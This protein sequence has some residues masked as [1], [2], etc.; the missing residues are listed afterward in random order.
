[1]RNYTRLSEGL[2][3]YR[4]VMRSFI[5]TAI[6]KQFP[7]GDWFADRVLP[8]VTPQ[9]MDNLQRDLLR[10]REEGRVGRGKGGPEQVLDITHF[11]RVISANWH[12][13]FSKFLKDR[14]LLTY[15]REVGDARNEWAHP[16]EG[17]SD[18]EDVSRILDSCARVVDV[19]DR[20]TAA[21][22]RE[23]RD[24]KVEVTPQAAPEPEAPA[25]PEAKPSVTGLTPWREVV[26]PHPDV[27][28]GRYQKAEFAADLQEVV[29]GRA[30]A[31]YGDPQEF[32]RRTFVTPDMRRLLVGVAQR[33]RGDG[34]D[35]VI[36]LK[37]AFGGG[38]THTLLAVFHMVNSADKIAQDPDVSGILRDAG[39][40]L[41]A[42][43]STAV[44]VGTY[45][46]PVTPIRL[47][48]ETGGVE[49]HTLWGDMAYQLAGIPGYKLVANH[50]SKGVAPGA[51]VMGRLFELA[52]PSVILIDEL[53]AY[54][55]SVPSRRQS[56]DI[57][58]SYN[59]HITFCQALTEAAKNAE[60]V[61]VLVSVPESNIEYG[62]AHGARIATQI[63]NIFQR[64]GSPWQPVGGHEAFEVVRRRLFGEIKDAVARDKTVDAFYQQYRHGDGEFPPECREPAY[65]ERMRASYP[66]HPEVF[67]RLYVDWAGSIDRFQRTR[68]VLRLM[69][70]AIHRLWVQND[71]EPMIMPGS[72]P[73]YDSNVRQQLVGYL[74]DNW[75]Q[76]MDIDIDG[77]SC[78]ASNIERQN[79]RYGQVQACRRLTRT[80]F[81]GSVPGKAHAGLDV[82]RIFLGTTQPKEGAAVYGDALRTLGGRLS[83]LYGSDNAYWFE[84]RPNLNRM[85]GDRIGRIGDQEALDEIRSRLR[86]PR[87]FQDSG[88]FVTVHSAPES[89]SDVED[90]AR[91]RLVVLGPESPHRNDLDESAAVKQAAAILESRGTTPRTHRNMLVFVAADEETLASVY[92]DTKRYRGWKSI[93]DDAEKGVIS[94]DRGQQRQANESRD[95]AGSTVDARLVEAYRWLIVPEQEGTDPIKYSAMSLSGGGLAST[96][97]LGVRASTRLA[98]DGLLIRTWAPIHLKRELDQWIWKDGQTHVTLKQV[99]AY[100]ATY[101]YFSRLRDEEVFKEVVRNG[102]RTKDYFG[103]A[104]GLDGSRYLGLVFGEPPRNIVIDDSSLL[105]RPEISD[106]QIAE[107]T[108]IASKPGDG[109]VP[110]KPGTDPIGPPPET[111]TATPRRFYG[112]IKLNPARLSSSA[113][114]IGDEI[115]QH[116]KALVGSDVEVTLEI[117]AEIPE[118]IP[119]SVVR[120]ISENAA[121]LKFEQFGF[122]AE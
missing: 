65:A 67:E 35:P 40:P 7:Q 8:N 55:R 80:I 86:R 31:E 44:L 24:D 102:V 114:Q 39:G 51:E 76:P 91:A 98:T 18:P 42:N 30:S 89:P 97:P 2:K 61:A 92:E 26:A 70:D 111:P 96:G 20:A 11:M 48:E 57:T 66:I 113:G 109:P 117:H 28:A 41:P 46:D 52:G 81:L 15:M 69:A 82:G 38:K 99:W 85:A 1:M 115:V 108:E 106:R 29:N 83:Y 54:L 87:Q 88:D 75:N 60:N 119:D 77:D 34:G 95:S 4:D 13:V 105:V 101:P 68:G 107:E 63:S 64:V 49:P 116:L 19:F 112:T 21:Q 73:L 36:D 94:L 10:A 32:F 37:T 25:A 93:S 45:L 23:L 120:T 110:T 12:E 56:G 43:T 103:Y 33:L 62:D 59:T 58:G 22:L 121:T 122:E 78:E 14:K 71:Q 84:V 100:L 50:D 6:R 118:G 74:D 53:V 16:P 9:Q 47:Q 17:D 3:L 72:M 27:Q 5:G 79:Q 90:T 104:D